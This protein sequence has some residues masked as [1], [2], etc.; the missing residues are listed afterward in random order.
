VT[1]PNVTTPRNGNPAI[2]VRVPSLNATVR[3]GSA[4]GTLFN[5]ATVKFRA[6]GSG[7]GT[8]TEAYPNQT[9]AT[10][11]GTNGRI[12]ATGFPYGTYR[13]CAQ[14]TVAGATRFSPTLTVN[15]NDPN[16][17]VS[18]PTTAT[19]YLPPLVIPTSGSTGSCTP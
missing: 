19:N 1:I 6:T 16:G 10:V 18:S 13:I 9:S 17:T 7:C 2:T 8:A 11:G 15:N 5:G 4:T 3:T 12:A 14:G